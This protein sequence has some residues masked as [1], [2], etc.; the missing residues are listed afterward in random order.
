[1]DVLTDLILTGAM[2]AIDKIAIEFH[3]TMG[4]EERRKQQSRVIEE[5]CKVF[6]NISNK[7]QI[8]DVDDESYRKANFDLPVCQ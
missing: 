7:F 5:A 4:K 6:Q 3:H 8:L 1:M 2:S